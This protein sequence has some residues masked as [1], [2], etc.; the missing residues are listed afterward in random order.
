MIIF[1]YL[2]LYINIIFGSIFI[3]DRFNKKIETT[4]IISLLKDILILYI[5][6]IINL[7]NI[8]VYIVIIL[9]LLLGIYTIIKNIKNKT[10]NIKR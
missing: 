2:L 5:F 1:R 10:L 7:L 4:I 6:G 9:N 8:G 3:S